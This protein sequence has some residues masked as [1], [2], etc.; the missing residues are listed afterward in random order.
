M[1]RYLNINM[2]NNNDNMNKT[3][4]GEY[5]IKDGDSDYI[6]KDLRFDIGTFYL[7]GNFEI[8]G[9]N[10]K[11]GFEINLGASDKTKY[12]Y[13]LCHCEEDGYEEKDVYKD[14]Y[15]AL[16]MLYDKLNPK[17]NFEQDGK[18]IVLQF[19]TNYKD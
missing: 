7:R 18:D 15:K 5:E 16:D 10:K 17:I 6:F 8:K 11:G 2:Q 14:V 19:R 4:K 3:I 1:Q 9:T 12:D 13:E